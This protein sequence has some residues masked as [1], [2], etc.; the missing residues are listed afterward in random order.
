[1]DEIA[2]PGPPEI[3]APPAV[4]G[5]GVFRCVLDCASGEQKTVELSEAEVLVAE[6]ARAV[7]TARRAEIEASKAA[8]ATVRDEDTAIVR[9]VAKT[10]STIA[11]IA[12]LAGID[13]SVKEVL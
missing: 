3:E 6:T 7:Q 4:P 1:M 9:E 13:L 2:E 11:A 12:R 5:T 8:A 10:D